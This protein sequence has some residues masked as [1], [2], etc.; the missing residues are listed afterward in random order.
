MEFETQRLIIRTN[1]SFENSEVAIPSKPNVVDL[2]K[3]QASKCEDGGF[4]LYLKENNTFV[5]HVSVTFTRKYFELTVGTEEQF[6]KQGYMSEALPICI[7]CIFQNS[8]VEKIYAL[9]GNIEP[10][11]SRKLI[12]K[13]GFERTD[14][15]DRPD[16]EEWYVM[17]NTSHIQPET[18]F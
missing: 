10:V 1:L 5:G 2:L 7:D 9:R 14:L 8:N 4:A 6:R 18:S 11:A 17:K 16:F 3:I 13:C 12:E 15:E